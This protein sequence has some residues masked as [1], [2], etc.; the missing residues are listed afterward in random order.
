MRADCDVAIIGA[1]PYG[2]SL[3]AHL[4][5]YDIRLRIFGRPM[6]SW[7]S[8]MPQSMLL[9]S[10]GF[11][12]NLSDPDSKLTLDAFCR[13]NGIDYADQGHPIALDTFV[14]YG[15]TFQKT[16]LPE[17]DTKEIVRLTRLGTGFQLQAADGETL[18]ARRVVVAVGI[19]NFA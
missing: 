9:K 5:Q 15:Q 17:L 12:S 4:R 3:A 19:S 1:G 8:Q 11:A 6:H 13:T 18:S 14:A 2:L 7:A 10:E 16:F